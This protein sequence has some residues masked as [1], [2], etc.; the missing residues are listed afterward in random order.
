MELH[1][2]TLAAHSYALLDEMI[3]SWTTL[4][5]IS[6]C[7]YMH[8]HTHTHSHAHTHH[9]QI[10]AQKRVA[11]DRA[12]RDFGSLLNDKKVLLVFIRS[13]EE[14]RG[15]SIKDKSIVGSLLMVALH[16]RLDYATE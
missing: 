13:L 1:A 14:Q 11:M 15:F 4:Y 12:I 5:I 16:N 8:S 9:T 3:F 6:T 2:L 7:V 10:S